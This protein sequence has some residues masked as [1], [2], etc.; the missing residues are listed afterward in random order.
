MCGLTL[1]GLSFLS[2]TPDNRVFYGQDDQYFQNLTEFEALFT[3][4]TRIA[5]VVSCERAIEKCPNLL[6]STLWLTDNS[7]QL[8][9]VTRVDSLATYP[10]LVSENETIT[11]HS[12]LEYTCPETSCIE[13]RLDQFDNEQILGRYIDSTRKTIAVIPSLELT[14]GSADAVSTSQDAS[15]ELLHEHRKLWPDLDIRYVG[16]VPL[17]QAFVDASDKDLTSIFAIAIT[18]IVVLL[19]ITLQS[20]TLVVIMLSVGLLTIGITLGIAGWYGL[21]L[22]T[23]TATIP[24]VLFTLIVATSMHYFM[25]LIRS[26]AEHSDWAAAQ[27]SAAALSSQWKPILL[28]TFTTAT[29]LLSL[30]SVDSPPVKDIGVWTALGMIVGTSILL[31]FVPVLTSWLPRPKSSHW[32]RNLQAKLNAYARVVERDA[33]PIKTIL[34]LILA[35]STTIVSLN[36]DDDF[37]RYFSPENDFRQDTEHVAERLFGPSNVEIQID[38]ARE[39]GIFEPAYVDYVARITKYV[40]EHG[41]VRN[42][43]SYSDVIKETNNHFGEGDEFLKLEEEAIAQMF[44]A[45]ELS[46][47][48]GQSTTSFVDTSR[49]FARITISLADISS[50]EITNLENEL[51]DWHEAQSTPYQFLVTGES[52]PISHLSSRNIASML[53]S[54]S[55]TF[56]FSA[57]L[58]ALVFRNYKI[59]LVALISTVVPVVIGFGLWSLGSDTIGLSTTVILSVCIG[60]VIDD[61]IHLIYRHYDAL[62]RLDM[63]TRQ[64]AA[65]S[66]HRVGSALVTTTIVIVAGFLVL[67]LSEFE[68]NSTFA[69]CSSLILLSAL[70]FDLIISP[71]LLVWAVP[72]ST[73]I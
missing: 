15:H 9:F 27:A 29:C 59:G 23:A 57:T 68:L 16:T 22:N 17:M 24:L 1:P 65:F 54:I 43:A 26:S 8:P 63:G 58:L 42:V 56:L 7:H 21:V 37:V 18:V 2:V 73:Q 3:S 30:L 60:V 44:M 33:L 72:D 19:A 46:L 69:A 49:R 12:L 40:R 41:A 38:S 13:S 35:S 67:L 45:Y 61:S 36:V 62:K 47:E 52:I 53:I 51:Y 48:H 4:N 20:A 25:H 6:R 10:T 34:F 50:L 14:I 70:F 71:K 64:A 32:Q 55:M 5:F 28:T 66:V 31:I 11:S 39:N